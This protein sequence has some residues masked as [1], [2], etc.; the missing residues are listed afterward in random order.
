M[1][2]TR[3]GT[4]RNAIIINTSTYYH[5]LPIVLSH[6]FTF[7]HFTDVKLIMCVLSV[8]SSYEIKNSLTSTTKNGFHGLRRKM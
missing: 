2:Y 1:L 8:F 7:E 4:R 3:M 5:H 6:E